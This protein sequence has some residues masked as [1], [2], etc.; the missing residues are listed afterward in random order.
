[1]VS[2][3][4]SVRTLA[5]I[6]VPQPADVL[7]PRQQRKMP[8]RPDMILQFAHYLAERLEREGHEGVR[9]TADVMAS[10]NAREAQPLIDP[11]ADLGA[12]PRNLLPAD[13]IVPLREPL[14]SLAE[15]RRIYT[16]QMAAARKNP[17][18][19][20]ELL[21]SDETSDE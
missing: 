11:Y 2:A 15:V 1:M 7:I 6:G 20:G 16:E 17:S 4:F 21:D 13:W 19:E 12:K 3:P 18:V 5:I 10:L 9:V 8:D 14:P